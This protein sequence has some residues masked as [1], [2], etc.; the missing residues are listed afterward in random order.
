[1]IFATIILVFILINLLFSTLAVRF[2]LSFG[3]AYTLSDSTK[4][5]LKHLDD[6]VNIKF[7]VS[8]DLPTRLIP[9]KTEVADLLNEY[10]R[11]SR[12]KL[13]VKFLDP[14]K[15]EK[16]ASDAKESGIP[17]IQFSQL[18]RDK[19]AVSSSYFGIVISYGDKKEMLPQVTEIESLEYDLTAAIYKLVRVEAIK[20]GIVGQED[21]FNPQEDN[22][23][24]LKKLLSQQFEI[25]SVS[26]ATDSGSISTSL[27]TILILAAGDKRYD[28][29]ELKLIKEYL[30]RKG[31]AVFFVDGVM[32]SDNLT[33]SAADHNLFSLLTDYGVTVNKNL[34]LSSQ[35]ELVNFGSQEFSLLVPYPFWIKTDSFDDSVSYFSNLTYVTF[36]WVSSL[37]RSEKKDITTKTLIKTGKQSWEQKENFTLNP[38]TI[39]Q[40][41]QKDLKEFIVSILS[42]KRNGG[43]IIVIPSSRFV[44]ERYLG[45]GSGNLE[46]VLNILNDFASEG[47]LSGIHARAVSLYPVPDLPESQKDIFK[48]ANIFF[49]PALFALWGAYRLMKRR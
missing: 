37:T 36:P 30:D 19:Y 20:I 48:Y 11:D 42:E 46:Y 18:D 12:G 4:K 45:R 28:T 8:S 3:K 22:L 26:L 29:H 33:T 23:A 1:M 41:E 31:K 38:Q 14:K 27:K 35:A 49:L 2:D 15:D 34:L 43:K 7:F 47:V 13:R 10:Q 25:E 21:A 40:P 32:I 5:I 16:A 9:L 17:E 6:I 44:L 39:T 24:S